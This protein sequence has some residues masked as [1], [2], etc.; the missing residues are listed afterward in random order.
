[1]ELKKDGLRAI[2]LIDTN[3][4]RKIT[5]GVPQGSI[6]GPLLFL[7]YINDLPD[8]NQFENILFADDT[9]LLISH[10]DPAQLISIAN[11]QLIEV[12]KWFMANALTVHPEKTMFMIFNNKNRS[13]FNE[14]IFLNL[15]KLERARE[16]EKSKSIK[17]FGLYLDEKTSSGPTTSITLQ[18]KLPI[19]HT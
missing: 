14:K 5:C 19:I 4:P 10:K 8:S 12:S 15:S 17:F 9:T 3:T 2:W 11:L 7:I 13:Q 1:M 16:S 6:L 18:R